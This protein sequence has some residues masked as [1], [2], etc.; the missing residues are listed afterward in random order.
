ML[1]AGAPKE[2]VLEG[3]AVVVTGVVV[4]APK[5]PKVG[6]LSDFVAPKVNPELV[7][8]PLGFSSDFEGASAGLEAT[9]PNVNVDEVL[10]VVVV[11]GADDPKENVAGAVGA[12]VAVVVNLLGSEKE[13]STFFKLYLM[14]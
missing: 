3:A 8:P 14:F 6:T 10:E 11:E 7:A 9:A 5:P 4:A 13:W 2:K 12:T 1:A